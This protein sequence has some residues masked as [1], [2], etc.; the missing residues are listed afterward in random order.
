MK[1][2][3]KKL[4]RALRSANHHAVEI[5]SNRSQAQR[6]EAM[7][8]FRI[9]RYRVLVATDIAARGL[10]IGGI[11]LLRSEIWMPFERRAKGLDHFGYLDLAAEKV[12]EKGK[13]LGDG[14][15]I[16]DGSVRCWN[17]QR[18]RRVGE[19]FQCNPDAAGRATNHAIGHY[20]F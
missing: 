15:T 14:G 2:S 10:D 1:F 3:A 5:H 20:V 7:D 13:W 9:G 8:G 12:T 19:Q 16:R 11:E 18:L 4:A 6:R 17:P